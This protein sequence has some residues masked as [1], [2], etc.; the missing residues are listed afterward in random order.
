MVSECH[1]VDVLSE[2]ITGEIVSYRALARQIIDEPEDVLEQIK[3]VRLE[4][5]QVGVRKEALFILH[6]YLWLG[7]VSLLREVFKQMILQ[8][9]ANA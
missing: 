3:L 6:L 7:L 8:Y 1:Q 4:R 9:P 2:A 5:G